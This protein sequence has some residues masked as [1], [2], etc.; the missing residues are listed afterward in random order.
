MEFIVS[1]LD[2]QHFAHLYGLSDEALLNLGVH[3]MTVDG[4][5]GAPCRVSLRELEVGARVLLLNHCHL[6][7][8][9]PYRSSH[10]IF[11]GDR[12]ELGVMAP[13]ELPEIIK[14]RSL[15]SVRAFDAHGMMTDAQL[16]EGETAAAKFREMLAVPETAYLHTHTAGRGCYLARV[17]R[18]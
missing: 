17:D 11:V 16:V 15:I 2:A 5:P 9:S 10:A 6:D 3:A 13:G 14:L 8:A 7:V 1:A 4:R 12:A 18:A